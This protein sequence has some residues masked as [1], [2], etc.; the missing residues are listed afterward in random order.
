MEFIIGV[1][2]GMLTTRNIMLCH[3]A[4]K[5]ERLGHVVY[6]IIGAVGGAAYVLQAIV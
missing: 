6:G 5:G 2:L 1:A 4:E 3:D